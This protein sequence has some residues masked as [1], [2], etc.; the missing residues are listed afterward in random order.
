MTSAKA[1]RWDNGAFPRSK[2]ISGHDKQA[3]ADYLRVGI[4]PRDELLEELAK[5]YDRSTRQIE[6]YISQCSPSEQEPYEETPHKQEIRNLAEA[7]KNE[8][9]SIMTSDSF[10]L[11]LEPGQRALFG[12]KLPITISKDEIR[13]TLSTEGEGEAGVL[14]KVLCAHLETSDFT[15]VLTDIASWRSGMTDN[16]RKYHGL[17][18]TVRKK[19]ERTYDT[20]IAVFVQIDSQGQPNFNQSGFTMYFPLLICASALEQARGSSDYIDME[21]WRKD[22]D[23]K[24]GDYT[25]YIGT[26]DEHMQL[27][28]DAHREWISKC[29][30]WK[31]TRAITKQRQDL[32]DIAATI[33]EQ[34]HTFIHMER[35][36][37]HC[38]L[39][40]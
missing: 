2:R 4:R 34:L 32:D 24:Y 11:E 23:L 33:N 10:I 3:M 35:L 38:E 30:M 37:G 6:R 12:E 5:K 27:F 17:F 13:V 1:T 36:P 7:L 18:T 22:L 9:K 40:S 19:L 39:C 14:P 20:S 25:I 29:A 26:S 15:K 8:I 21:Y 16:L 28:V 31:Q